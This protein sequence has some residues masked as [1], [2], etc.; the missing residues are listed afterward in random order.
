MKK[1]IVILLM[2]LPLGLM[3]QSSFDGFFDK[4][5]GTPYPFK[6]EGDKS[7]EWFFRPAATMT[8]VQFTYDKEN[9]TFHSSTFSSVGVGIGF[10]HYT[11]HNGTFIN[12]Y[13]FNALIMLDASQLDAG[14][15]VAG[16][17]NALQFVNVGCGYNFT[18]KQFFILTGAVYNF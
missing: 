1:L 11:E 9:K 10:Q 7:I 14:I 4:K 6:A 12:N 17:V 15:A 5:G 18:G 16:T 3:A 2:M 13:G 8:A